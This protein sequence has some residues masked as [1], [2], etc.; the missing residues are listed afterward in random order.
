MTDITPTYKY[1]INTFDVIPNT[2]NLVNVIVKVNIMILASY[3]Y[4]TTSDF[5]QWLHHLLHHI[6]HLM[7]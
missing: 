1:F 7:N 3:S 6:F 4:F 5:Y 2:N